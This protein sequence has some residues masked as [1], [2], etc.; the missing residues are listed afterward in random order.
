MYRVLALVVVVLAGCVSPEQAAWNRQRQA[1]QEAQQRAAYREGLLS[2]CDNIGFKRGTDAH[3]NCVL[4]QHQQ[5]M[6]IL[7]TAVLMQQQ[8]Q[9]QRAYRPVVPPVPAYR[10]PIQTRCFSDGYGNTNCTT[11]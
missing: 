5:N 1:E 10:P 2:S 9:Q 11:N 7:G 8:Q 4:T 6:R 3:A